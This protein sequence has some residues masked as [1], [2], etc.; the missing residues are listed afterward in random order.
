MKLENTMYEIM[1][2]S[3]TV[4][5][6]EMVVHTSRKRSFVTAVLTKMWRER[7]VVRT[8]KLSQS[9]QAGRK[10]EAYRLR[11][12]AEYA[13]LATR[14]EG[15]PRLPGEIEAEVCAFLRRNPESSAATI[16]EKLSMEWLSV[17]TALWRLRKRKFVTSKRGPSP[18]KLGPREINFYSVTANVRHKLL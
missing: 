13:S 9:R 6:G 1:K 11:T 14:T 18:N 7:T 17:Y 4:T 2:A 12:P 3:G 16:M 8:V 15:L 5:I 10:V